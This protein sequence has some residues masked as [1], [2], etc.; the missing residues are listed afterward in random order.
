MIYL[1]ICNSFKFDLFDN[2]IVKDNLAAS[3]G[4]AQTGPKGVLA[5]YRQHQRLK[6]EQDKLQRQQLVEKITKHSMC[7]S[8]VN[9]NAHSDRTFL[10]GNKEQQEEG[11]DG[12]DDV[13]DETE[14]LALEAYRE[15]RMREWADDRMNQKW[16]G[17]NI[18]YVF[19]F[20]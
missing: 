4:R 19:I 14:R 13:A 7:L 12:D 20:L 5:D 8:N 15:Q 3:T 1:F 9:S 10:K 6:Q 11:M 18:V 17:Y 2:I 16:K